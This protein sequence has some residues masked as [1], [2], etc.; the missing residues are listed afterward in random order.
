MAGYNE[1]YYDLIRTKKK[2]FQ[3]LGRAWTNGD[4]NENFEMSYEAVAVD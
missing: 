3:L 2:S 1:N 4:E